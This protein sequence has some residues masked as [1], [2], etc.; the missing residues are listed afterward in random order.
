MGRASDSREAP[1]ESGRPVGITSKDHPV[2]ESSVGHGG[3]ALVLPL[4]SVL[5][6]GS[7]VCHCGSESVA[8]A[9]CQAAMPPQ[10]GLLKGTLSGSSTAAVGCCSTFLS[11]S[12]LSISLA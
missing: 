8:V 1:R 5:G 6:R 4:S 3:P 7:P 12:F 9:G 11:L 10:R 2:E